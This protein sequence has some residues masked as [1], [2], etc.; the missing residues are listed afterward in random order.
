MAC[1]DIL[2]FEQ[3]QSKYLLEKARDLFLEIAG[4]WFDEVV[5]RMAGKK[6][7]L[8]E[9]TKVLFEM[10]YNLMGKMAEGLVKYMGGTEQSG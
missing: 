9:M 4:Q 5:S 8:E 10:R 6:P 3:Y 1:E 2:F 7:T